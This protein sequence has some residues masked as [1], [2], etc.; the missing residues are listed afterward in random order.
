MGTMTTLR[1]RMSRIKSDLHKIPEIGEEVERSLIRLGF[2]T[3]KSL[4]G[5][6]PESIYEKECLTRG[7]CLDRNR[8]YK[9]RCAVYFANTEKPDPEKLHWLY[10]KDE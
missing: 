6:N 8:L 7:R 10:W 4:H 9:Y 2:K 5:V 1:Q 3:L